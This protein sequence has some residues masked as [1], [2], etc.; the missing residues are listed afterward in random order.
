MTFAGTSLSV[1]RF[2]QDRASILAF[3]SDYMGPVWRKDACN[4]TADFFLVLNT[5]ATREVL[6][7]YGL[8]GSEMAVKKGR[9]LWGRVKW[10]AMY[11]ERIID[12]INKDQ[13]AEIGPVHPEE[14]L[15]K[16]KALFATKQESLNFGHLAEDTY[17]IVVAELLSKL[18]QLQKRG[19]CERLLDKLLEA[20]FSADILDRPH[21]LDQESDMELVEH[22]FA[23]VESWED[24]LEAELTG[25]FKIVKSGGQMT[26]TLRNDRDPMDAFIHL[27]DTVIRRDL[28][29]VSCRINTLSANIMEKGFVIADRRID[30]LAVKLEEYG[31]AVTPQAGDKLVVR[32]VNSEIDTLRQ[33]DKLAAAMFKNG[34]FIEN[35]TIEKLTLRIMMS[36][37]TLWSDYRRNDLNE[38]LKTAGFEIID[39]IAGCSIIKRIDAQES[40]KTNLRKM[41]DKWR[42]KLKKKV[43]LLNGNVDQLLAEWSSNGFLIK[44]DPAV[45]EG[46]KKRLTEQKLQDCVI[47][48]P[49]S[50]LLPAKSSEYAELGGKQRA[51]LLSN[52]NNDGFIIID[53]DIEGLVRLVKQSMTIMKPT[54]KL[55][56]DMWENGFITWGGTGSTQLR[57][58]LKPCTISEDQRGRFKVTGPKT[59]TLDSRD[60]LAEELSNDGFPMV[61]KTNHSLILKLAER[62]VIDAVIRFALSHGQLD[63]KFAILIRLVSGRSGLGHLAE[64]YLAVVSTQFSCSSRR[65]SDAGDIWITYASIRY[66]L[67]IPSM[68]KHQVGRPFGRPR[69]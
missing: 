22:G 66:P 61:S 16:S 50:R 63:E 32:L 15:E 28:A 35:H 48:E 52:L 44:A 40:D 46:L 37:F 2:L 34:T 51:D 8:D 4:L 69:E 20:A 64:H 11:A 39:Q 41:I 56:A 29:I 7:C 57:T 13:P 67:A 49:E 21:V 45:R 5:S 23:I 6:R 10:T 47:L 36:G 31:F 60:R 17:E 27:L 19:D 9:L 30:R 38:A 62:V 54:N 42:K 59:H 43:V 14:D 24:S 3:K 12:E 65:L 53:Q 1:N 55:T 18:H 33:L 68:P 25:E 58:L 26:A